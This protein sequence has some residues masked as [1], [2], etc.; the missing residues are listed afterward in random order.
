MTRQATDNLYIE[1]DYFTPEE[2][3]VYIGEAQSQANSSFSVSATVGVIKQAQSQLT[4]N[5]SVSATISHIEGADLFAFTEAQLAIQIS[6]I[7]NTEITAASTFSVAIDFVR[8]RDTG[9]EQD[10]VISAIIAGLRSRT[11]TLETQAA[12][13]LAAEATRIKGTSATLTSTFTQD[14]T[15]LRIKQNTTAGNGR[16]ASQKT[17]TRTGNPVLSSAQS[18]F[19]GHS[20]RFEDGDKLSVDSNIDFAFGTGA[21]TIELWARLDQDDTSQALVDLRPN[22]N[23]HQA[24]FL[25]VNSSNDVELTVNG[26]ERIVSNNPSRLFRNIWYHIAV[27]K[28]SNGVHRMFINGVQQ[29]QT[30]SNSTA[31]TQ[32]P[33]NIGERV[34]GLNDFNGY[35][36][37]LRIIKGTALYTANFTAPTSQLTDIAGTVLLL[38]M[39]VVTDTTNFVDTFTQPQIT[40]LTYAS[41]AQVSPIIN[42]IKGYSANVS[43]TS[44]ISANQIRIRDG[45]SNNEVAFSLAADNTKLIQYSSDLL[46]QSTVSAIISHIE[47]ADIVANGFASLSA[48]LSNVTKETAVALETTASQSTVTGFLKSLDSN[49]QSTASI[50]VLPRI[51]V[52]NTQLTV[53]SGG[54]YNSHFINT[55]SKQ[56]GAGSLSWNIGDRIFPTSNI[57]WTGSVFKTFTTGY[58]WTSSDGLTWTRTTNNLSYSIGIKISFVNARYCFL[59]GSSLQYSTDGDS[60][61]T[62]TI[63]NLTSGRAY[64]EVFYVNGQ[65]R[66]FRSQLNNEIRVFS[67]TNLTSWTN[68]NLLN[69]VSSIRDITFNN[70]FVTISYYFE[71]FPNYTN[72]QLRW[73]GTTTNFWTIVTSTSLQI[74]NGAWDGSNTQISTLGSTVGTSRIYVRVN[75]TV[76]NYDIAGNVVDVN[77]VNGRWF[78]STDI[79]IYSGTDP[80]NLTLVDSVATER[81]IFASSRY[82]SYSENTNSLGFI[83]HSTNATTWAS[84]QVENISGVPGS[85]VYSRDNNS[86]LGNFSTIDFW[87]N[88]TGGA[89]GIAFIARV[90]EIVESASRYLRI[91]VFSDSN[92][93]NNFVIVS[94]FYDGAGDSVDARPLPYGWNHIRIVQNGSNARIFANGVSED[95]SNSWPTGQIIAPVVINNSIYPFDELLISDSQ[96]SLVTDT[97]CVVPTQPWENNTNT[98]LLLHFDSDLF[99][100]SRFNPIISAALAT[101]TQVSAFTRVDYN[102]SI[103]LVSNSNLSCSAQKSAEII[104][105]AFSDAN[106]TASIDKIKNANAD[107]VSE[108]V[109]SVTANSLIIGEADLN[110][111]FNQTT[112]SD[113]IRDTVIS[114]ESIATQLSAVVKIATFFINADVV[115]QMAINAVKTTDVDSSQSAIS[116]ISIDAIRSVDYSADISGVALTDVSADRTRSTLVT[117]AST[118][119]VNALANADRSA[120]AVLTS[121]FVADITTQGLIDIIALVMSSGILALTPNI[122][123]STAVDLDSEFTQTTE[124]F[125]SL[126]Q[127]ASADLV[128]EFTQTTN[129]SRTRS[130]A[131]STDSVASQLVAIAK[132]GQGLITL[133]SACLLSCEALYTAGATVNA[134]SVA[135]VITD[136]SIIKQGQLDIQSQADIEVEGTTNIVGEGHLDSEFALSTQASIIQRLSASIT[137]STALICDTGRVR[138]FASLEVSAATMAVTGQLIRD[139]VIVTEAIATEMVIGNKLILI[140]ANLVSRFTVTVNTSVVHLNEYVYVIPAEGR[141][142]TINGESR[143]RKIAGE[144]REFTIRR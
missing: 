73:N 24:V 139:V 64:S 49:L 113:R 36:D 13:S 52:R 38:N 37:D 138:P 84:D 85:I 42:Q 25:R 102:S 43:A 111:E 70:G 26:D 54:I 96:L 88:L 93:N 120:E 135:G 76:T 107:L 105:S 100:D 136:I 7:K 133:E 118:A 106:L 72:S 59:D 8:Q 60:W 17:V 51:L 78:I 58:T 71:Q 94:K 44:N 39:N 5:S 15:A 144:S 66:V 115:A 83:R 4:V 23:S 121:E 90:I 40:G 97:T 11:V 77:F 47:G 86:D 122:I 56:F 124:T 22:T 80:N 29:T 1:L 2:Y 63:T 35:I 53:N 41:S 34:D 14:V 18:Q 20:A 112:D 9:S 125:D 87:V 143:E 12:F 62:S 55:S 48:E 128:S 114:T 74:Q 134:E 117:L 103:D 142:Y 89:A 65:W 109:V 140:N 129:N 6:L 123:K 61:S 45:A 33:L 57:V 31:Y 141:S 81:V 91:S 10:A 79:G 130:V 30:W 19:G 137:A 104:L 132:I 69:S 27:T 68:A 131:I 119:S 67:S 46:S 126:S 116:N 95:T 92:P 50:L 110:V 75:T 3:Y 108:S 16:T 127:Q 82:L 99:D 98:D 32:G 101:V 21:W 28:A